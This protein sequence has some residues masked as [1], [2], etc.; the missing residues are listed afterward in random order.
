[1]SIPIIG[2]WAFNSQSATAIEEKKGKQGKARTE[3]RILIWCR[4]ELEL[5]RSTVIPKPSPPTTLNASRSS[6][7]LFLE[8]ID[9]AKV[10]LKRRFQ[11]A[12]LFELPPTLIHRCEVLPEQCVI[13]VTLRGGRLVGV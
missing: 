4:D 1:M 13:Y 2:T 8:V 5:L 6:I 3:Q 7:K 10:P 9:R 11:L 12:A